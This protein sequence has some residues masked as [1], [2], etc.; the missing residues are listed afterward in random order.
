[1]EIILNKY[2]ELDTQ[3]FIVDVILH[4]SFSAVGVFDFFFHDYCWRARGVL[5]FQ[6]FI[7]ILLRS[8]SENAKNYR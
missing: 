7:P 4:C 6:Y 3:I 1:M 2:I 8:Y 5:C